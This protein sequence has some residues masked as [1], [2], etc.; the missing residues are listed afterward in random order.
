MLREMILKEIEEPLNL[1]IDYEL[2]KVTRGK[3]VCITKPES[4]IKVYIIPHE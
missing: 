1:K 4:K 3:E 2:N